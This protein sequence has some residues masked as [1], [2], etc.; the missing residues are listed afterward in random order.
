M[1][2]S[3]LHGLRSHMHLPYCLSQALALSLG[4]FDAQC[5][6]SVLRLLP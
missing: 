4:F 2:V 3:H 5:A 6:C 1:L